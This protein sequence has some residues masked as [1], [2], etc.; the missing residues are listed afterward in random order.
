MNPALK[1]IWEH[2]RDLGLGALAHANRHAAYGAMENPRWPE[3]S[4]LQAAHAAELLIKARIAQE[5][6]LLIFDQVPRLSKTTEAPLELEDLFDK[7]RTFQWSDLPDRLWAATGIS[8]PS[9]SRFDR[10]GKLRNGIQHFAPPPGCDPSEETLRFVFEVID[11]FINDCWGYFAVDYDEDYEPYVYFVRA[12][13]S[14]EILFMV[15][16]AAAAEF[17]H[18][19]VDW[20]EVSADY[21]REMHTRVQNAKES[22][23]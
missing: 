1:G 2:I 9:K 11:P 14:R 21:R 5:H 12:L 18:W 4:V 10:F 3:L 15:S 6:P 8:L 16:P 13:I 7:G 22:A 23:S 19:D 17:D 20:T